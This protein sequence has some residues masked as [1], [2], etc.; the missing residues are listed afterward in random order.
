MPYYL[1]Y[2]RVCGQHRLAVQHRDGVV[3]PTHFL[4]IVTG[5]RV[6]RIPTQPPLRPSEYVGYNTPTQRKTQRP[7]DFGVPAKPASLRLNMSILCQ[8]SVSH[9]YIDCASTNGMML[10]RSVA[11]T[12]VLPGT[13][14]SHRTTL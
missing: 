14:Y 4:P 11:V 8:G 9:T 5:L 7:L 12:C 2:V 1:R 13:L 6:W 3:S 10:H